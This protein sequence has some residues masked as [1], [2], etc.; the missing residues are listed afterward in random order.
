M[1]IHT[2]RWSPDTCGCVVEYEWDD[3][4]PEEER[5]HTAGNIVNRCPAHSAN[6]FS[7]NTDHYST[8]LEENQRKNITIAEAMDLHPEE[9]V[10]MDEN[11]N[12]ILKRHINVK[13]IFHGTGKNRTL[14][15]AFKG[16]NLD[17]AKKSQIHS[18][19]EKRFGIGKVV[20]I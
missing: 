6:H 12:K 19:A 9:L 14:Q 1:T 10:T 8:V 4:L 15:I 11:G 16:A 3:A 7:D 17:K 5:V 18:R 2:T 20:V 13:H